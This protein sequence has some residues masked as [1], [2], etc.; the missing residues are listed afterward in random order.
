MG[1]HIVLGKKVL[2]LDLKESREGFFRR[3]RGRTFHV[4]WLK[5]EKA[6]EPK[7]ERLVRGIWKLRESEAERRVREE[8]VCKVEDSHRDKT[9][10]CTRDSS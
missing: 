4:E 3:G 9:G 5:M 1:K 7:V 10:E 6:R 8:Y 2:G